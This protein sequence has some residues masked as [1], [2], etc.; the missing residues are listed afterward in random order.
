[1]YMFN[2]ELTSGIAVSTWAQ[3]VFV[4]TDSIGQNQTIGDKPRA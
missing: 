2:T 1:M 4:G 3:R